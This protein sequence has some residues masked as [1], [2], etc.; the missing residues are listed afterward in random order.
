MNRIQFF[1]LTGLSSLVVLLL[2]GQV[3]LA[4][5]VAYDQLLLNRAQQGVTQAQ[6]FQ[7]NLKE[8]AI[9][10]YQDSQKLNDQQLKDLLIRQQITYK[11]NPTPAEDTAPSTSAPAP[12]PALTH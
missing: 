6:A 9:R 4:R 2:I 5:Q 10:I 8:V 1:V 11:P 12:T 7:G 3:L